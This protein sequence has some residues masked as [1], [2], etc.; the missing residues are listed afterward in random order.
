MYGVHRGMV[1]VIGA[2]GALFWMRRFLLFDGCTAGKLMHFCPPMYRS[3]ACRY[4]QSSQARFTS[5]TGH[6]RTLQQCRI[7]NYVPFQN[8]MTKWKRITESNIKF[9]IF[10]AIQT[11]GGTH[12]KLM[13]VI[14][15]LKSHRKWTILATFRDLSWGSEPW[16]SLDIFCSLGVDYR[17]NSNTNKTAVLCRW[18]CL[19]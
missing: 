18:N 6:L 19:F 14:M 9:L 13:S 1:V 12:V 7:A 16:N 10:L 8:K 17:R 2:L 3:K 5:R 4:L 15:M 11:T